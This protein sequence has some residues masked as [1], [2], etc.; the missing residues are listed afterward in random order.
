MCRDRYVYVVV[1]VVLWRSK[2]GEEERQSTE[3]VACLL[4][5]TKQFFQVLG[6]S[7][8][9]TLKSFSQRHQQHLLT[10]QPTDSAFSPYEDV[11]RDKQKRATRREKAEKTERNTEHDPWHTY[12]RCVSGRVRYGVKD[13]KGSITVSSHVQHEPALA[14]KRVAI[15]NR[16]SPTFFCFGEKR[17]LIT[18]SII[19]K[20]DK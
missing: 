2:R 14:V 13:F 18:S 5:E 6:N 20:R 4:S 19:Q 3:R 9:T 15:M 17:P 12:T 10:Y 8:S 16:R 11:Q 1:F 7:L